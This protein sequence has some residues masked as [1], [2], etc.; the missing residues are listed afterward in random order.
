MAWRSLGSAETPPQRNS[1]SLEAVTDGAF[2]AARS[3]RMWYIGCVCL[4]RLGALER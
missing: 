3:G 2:K 4:T 1:R